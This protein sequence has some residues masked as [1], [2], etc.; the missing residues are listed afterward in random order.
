[1]ESL[2]EEAIVNNCTGI[3]WTVA[4]WMKL[5]KGSMNDWVLKRIGIGLTMNGRFN[6]IFLMDGI[7]IMEVGEDMVT[8]LQQL[9]KQ[10]FVETFAE[11]NTKEDIAAYLDESLKKERL[12]YEVKNPNSLFYIA[13]NQ[14][15]P[16]GYLKVNLGAAQ[17][18][19]RE[20]ASLEIE[21]IYVK[22]EF[23][24]KKVGQ[25]LYDKALEIARTHHKS[26]IWLGVWEKNPRAIAFYRKNGFEAFDKHIFIMGNGKMTDIMMRKQLG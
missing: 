23:Y 12:K 26:S 20:E 8:E 24:G 11:S 17:T 3:K 2:R 7:E 13:R 18:E 5:D 22:S 1:M 4:P 14:S 15:K 6:F 9:A 25:L 10:T 21:R 16:V 19:L